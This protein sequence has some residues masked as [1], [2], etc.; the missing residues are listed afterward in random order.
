MPAADHNDVRGG[1][2][3]L[4]RLAE[5]AVSAVS[6][7]E[8]EDE[9]DQPHAEADDRVARRVRTVVDAIRAARR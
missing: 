5:L 9:G 6:A 2:E 4:E 3:A 7:G 1:D 8:D